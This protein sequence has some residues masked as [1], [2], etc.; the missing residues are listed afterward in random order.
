MNSRGRVSREVSG[1]GI[2]LSGITTRSQYPFPPYLK[3]GLGFPTL[4]EI[5]VQGIHKT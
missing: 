5:G 4:W 1:Y 2:I 3:G